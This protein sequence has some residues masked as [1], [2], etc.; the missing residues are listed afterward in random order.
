M[1]YYWPYAAEE[2][3]AV[4]RNRAFARS[5][6]ADIEAEAEIEMN[7]VWVVVLYPV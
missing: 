6:A 3:D 7:L 5:A 4:S 1:H 2:L